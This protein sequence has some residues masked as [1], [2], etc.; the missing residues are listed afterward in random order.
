MTAH[1]NDELQ[2][3]PVEFKL[4]GKDVTVSEGS[5][6]SELLN[7]THISGAEG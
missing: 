4:N 1:S 6:Y 3:M 5:R 7:R 2:A